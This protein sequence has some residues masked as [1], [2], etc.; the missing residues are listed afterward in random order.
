MKTRIGI[1]GSGYI[2]QGLVLALQGQDDLGVSR[3]LTRT[4]PSRCG[5]PA[6]NNELREVTRLH[7]QSLWQSSRGGVALGLQGL[8]SASFPA[9][10]LPEPDSYRSH[11]TRN[12]SARTV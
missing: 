4:N 6:T 10:P 1:A 8:S 5:F 11:I 3:V 9:K 7:G 2:A 12:A